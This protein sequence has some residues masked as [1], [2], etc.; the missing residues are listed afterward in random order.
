MR[1]FFDTNIVILY[2]REDSLIQ[3]IEDK[4][5]PLSSDNDA[6][7]SVVSKGELN[8]LS[9]KNDWGKVRIQKVERICDELLITDINSEDVIERY[10]EIDAFSQGRLKSRPSRFSARNMSKN[11][12]WIAATASITNAT[13]LTTDKDFDHLNG[14]FL[15]VEYIQLPT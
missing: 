15:N 11:D 5:N 6:F 8:A 13:L 7:L 14:V 9:K 2:L 4:F 3:L 1:Y 10:G 12:L